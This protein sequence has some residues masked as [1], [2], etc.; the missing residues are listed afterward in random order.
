MT[1]ISAL[2]NLMFGFM[3]HLKERDFNIQLKQ[4]VLTFLMANASISTLYTCLFDPRGRVCG[5]H[6]GSDFY[7]FPMVPFSILQCR[8]NVRNKLYDK[9]HA[10]GTIFKPQSSIN[11][12]KLCFCHLSDLQCVVI[13]YCIGVEKVELKDF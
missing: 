9:N 10:T 4:T 11:S 13:W 3:R 7:N 8:S 5:L 12:L 6:E 2:K 1:K